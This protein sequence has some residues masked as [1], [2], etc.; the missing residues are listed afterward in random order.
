MSNSGPQLIFDFE[1][2]LQIHTY[3]FVGR[4]E[5]SKIP[6]EYFQIVKEV[7]FQQNKCQ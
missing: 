5:I 1:N 4:L 2:Q 3:L 7:D 6:N